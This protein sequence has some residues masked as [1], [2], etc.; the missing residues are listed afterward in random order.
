MSE[1]LNLTRLV[2]QIIK[3]PIKTIKSTEIIS[4]DR[5][6][7]LRVFALVSSISLILTS[8]FSYGKLSLGII[9][10]SG[11]LGPIIM[12][13]ANNIIA[14]LYYATFKLFGKGIEANYDSIK[15][16]LYPLFLTFIIINIFISLIVHI[17]PS[18]NMVFRYATSL[19]FYTMTFFLL[20]YKLGQTITRSLVISLLPLFM[21]IILELISIVIK[22]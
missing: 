22:L 20:R 13:L 16:A 17:L 6:A 12:F 3:S 10:L 14:V 11:V 19:W 5:D 18:T 2:M 9:V 21:W 1:M 7:M 15:T 8:L 4:Y